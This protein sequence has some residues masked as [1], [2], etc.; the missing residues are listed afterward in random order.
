MVETAFWHYFDN[1]FVYVVISGWCLQLDCKF[2]DNGDVYVLHFF[3]SPSLIISVSRYQSVF[4]DLSRCVRAVILD[5][6]GS[7]IP[8]MILK[9]NL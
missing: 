6:L 8:F 3:E 1:L 5:S 4:V 7:C 2:L 9:Y